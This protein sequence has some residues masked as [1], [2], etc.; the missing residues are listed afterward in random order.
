MLVNLEGTLGAR[1]LSKCKRW[2]VRDCHA[3]QAPAGYA[4]SVFAASGI[5]AVNTANNHSYDYGDVGQSDTRKALAG[6]GVAVTGGVDEV[7]FTEVR[8]TRVALVGFATYGWGADLR[9]PAQVRTLVRRAKEGADIV[10]VMLHSVPRAPAR[11]TRRTGSSG[12]SAR[13]AATQGR[14]RISPSTRARISWS[15]R[16]HT[17]CEAWSFMTGASSPT[18]SATSSDTAAPSRSPVLSA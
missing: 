7:T 2:A 4:K 12:T 9:D 15:A 17:S 18:R 14:S 16:A 11:L 1:G 5:D 6:A 13:T 10:V 3:F 8:G